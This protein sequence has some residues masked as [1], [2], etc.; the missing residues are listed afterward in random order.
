MYT[1][2]LLEESV[3]ELTTELKMK[4]IEIKRLKENNK[5]LSKK[6][7]ETKVIQ[8]KKTTDKVHTYIYL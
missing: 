5:L 6:V 4:Q 3:G 8:F 7:S 1:Q 2:K